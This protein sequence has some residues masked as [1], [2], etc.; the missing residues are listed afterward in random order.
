MK[1]VVTPILLMRKQRF[2]EVAASPEA[3]QGVRGS[4]RLT[5][6]LGVGW[7]WVPEVHS[8]RVGSGHPRPSEAWECVSY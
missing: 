8:G 3:T 7:R 6:A 1:G 2:K 4:A 5:P